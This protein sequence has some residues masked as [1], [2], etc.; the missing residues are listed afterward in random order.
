[1]AD[2][3]AGENPLLGAFERALTE[4]RA[5]PLAGSETGVTIG[6]EELELDL[7]WEGVE[8]VLTGGDPLGW[9]DAIIDAVLEKVARARGGG[10]SWEEVKYDVV[11]LVLSEAGGREFAARC[12]GALAYPYAGALLIAIVFRV[13]SGWRY[14]QRA[15]LDAWDVAGPAVLT[16]AIENLRRDTPDGVV[17]TIEGRLYA[18]DTGDGLDSS[19]LLI[20]DELSEDAG[21]CGVLAAVPAR[22]VLAF[23]PFNRAGQEQLRSLLSLAH[24]CYGTWPHPISDGLF[25]VAPRTA[26]HIGVQREAGGTPRL[27]LPDELATIHADLVARGLW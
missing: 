15:E 19:R 17:Q 26:L 1:M 8:T 22:P 16:A 14:V 24:N 10:D 18:L 27:L 9:V 3:S 2:A 6:F 13:E 21:R 7:T 4:L 23:V 25:Y 5:A 11:P 12:P 20:L